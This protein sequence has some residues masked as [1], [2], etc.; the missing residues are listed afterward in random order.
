ML[1]AKMLTTL[2]IKC[3]TRRET[4]F[5]MLLLV[6]K[7]AVGA[8]VHCRCVCNFLLMSYPNSSAKTITDKSLRAET[9]S[10]HVEANQWHNF[11]FSPSV[12]FGHSSICLKLHFVLAAITFSVRTDATGAICSCNSHSG[13]PTH[14]S[15]L[16]TLPPETLHRFHCDLF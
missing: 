6:F 14:S 5:L 11:I 10:R 3:R 1:H 8:T 4:E 2:R 15:V 9:I 16:R 12:M 7:Y 13:T